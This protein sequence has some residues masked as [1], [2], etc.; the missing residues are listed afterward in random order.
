MKN[1]DRRIQD[2]VL[3]S[4]SIISGGSFISGVI[5]SMAP[6]IVLGKVEGDC[7]IEDILSVRES[8]EWVGSIRAHS[9]VINGTVKGNII[10]ETKLEVGST[11]RIQGNVTAGT[12]AI[13]SGAEIDGEIVMVNEKEPVYF[14]EKRNKT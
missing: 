6:V 3:K 8:G 4:P 13:A 7:E 1:K 12:L 9:V 14:K 10:T 5:K 2:N 11:G